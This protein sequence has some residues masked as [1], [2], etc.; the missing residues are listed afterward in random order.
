MKQRPAKGAGRGWQKYLWDSPMEQTG[1]NG[2]AGA[3]VKEAR[4]TTQDNK[5]DYR[6]TMC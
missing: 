1:K 5:I 4:L 2:E 6:I 3:R